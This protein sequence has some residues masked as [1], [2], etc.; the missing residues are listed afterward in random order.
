MEGRETDHKEANANGKTQTKATNSE[1]WQRL[2][3]P[4]SM[5]IKLL[6]Y[7]RARIRYNTR[8]IMPQQED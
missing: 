2:L 6:D 7:N 3:I 4:F 8:E 5:Y 1:C